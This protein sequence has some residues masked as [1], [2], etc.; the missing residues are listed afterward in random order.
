MTEFLL[1]LRP[2]IPHVRDLL[3]M[4]NVF[5]HVIHMQEAK[6][7]TESTK[8]IGGKSNLARKSRRGEYGKN[9]SPTSTRHSYSQ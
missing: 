5:C 4:T 3:L 2:D 8:S 7:D 6:G 1:T 9:K